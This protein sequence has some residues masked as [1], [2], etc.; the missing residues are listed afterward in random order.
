MKSRATRNE[1]VGRSGRVLKSSNRGRAGSS[2]E[3]DGCGATAMLR[4]MV[5]N[6]AREGRVCIGEGGCLIEK[7]EEMR[8]ELMRPLRAYRFS[9]PA[10]SAALPLLR[11]VP[12]SLASAGKAVK[13][14]QLRCGADDT[15]RIKAGHRSILY[16]FQYPFRSW[17]HK[18]P[19]EG[20]Q[21]LW[22]AAHGNNR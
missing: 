15:V 11:V 7:A 13:I 2:P 5:R 22:L 19:G 9:R 17:Q 14:Q 18:Q 10:H 12:G 8:F 4:Q 20:K 6:G 16:P 3:S 21:C 1:R